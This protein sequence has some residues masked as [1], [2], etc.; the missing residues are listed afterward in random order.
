M[1]ALVALLAAIIPAAAEQLVVDLSTPLVSI[2]TDFTGSEIALFG[3]IERDRQ[4]ISRRGPYQI[5]ATV[6][7]PLEDVLVQR[8]ERRFGIFVNAEGHL[9]TDVPSFYALYASES[10][11]ELIAPGGAAEDL[12]PDAIGRLGSK[13]EPFRASLAASRMETGQFTHAVGAV[14]LLTKTF[15]RAVIRLPAIAEAGVY[16]VRVHLFADGTRLD[17]HTLTFALRK[18][19]FEQDLWSFSRDRPLFYGLATVALALITGYVGG[20]VFRRN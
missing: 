16:T 18:A 12:S 4:T 11:R 17:T 5:V 14:E 9:F 15:F 19:G 10:A 6:A 13:R 8:K 3:V 2:E 1:A 20:V 7:G